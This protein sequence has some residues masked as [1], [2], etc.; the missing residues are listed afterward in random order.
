MFMIRWNEVLESQ[1]DEYIHSTL[2]HKLIIHSDESLGLPTLNLGL[3]LTNALVSK[4]RSNFFSMIAKEE[5]EK[6][7]RAN[8]FN[9]PSI[10][11]FISL[12]NVG[13]IFEPDLKIDFVNFLERW[14]KEYTLF[15]NWEGHYDN[16]ILFFLEKKNG[17]K[18]NLNHI[19]L[20]KL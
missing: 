13:I 12:E 10:G 8:I 14:S 19:S 1:V 15:L 3:E 18:I 11:K 16:K 17:I 2:K 4:E 9:D 6:L 20:L 7:I 5:L